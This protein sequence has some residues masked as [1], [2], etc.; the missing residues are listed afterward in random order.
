MARSELINALRD[1]ATEIR[2][3]RRSNELMRARLQ[4]IDDALQLMN[5]T[6]PTRHGE[7]AAPDIAWALDR[8]VEQLEE[9]D[10]ERVEHEAD[11]R[12]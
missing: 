8:H 3:L 7:G 9:Q 6:P 4:G 5:A 10:A 11:R 2:S 12:Q 1:A